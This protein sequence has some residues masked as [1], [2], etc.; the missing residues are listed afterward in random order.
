M[1]L[2]R[3]SSPLWRRL[4]GGLLALALVV[5]GLAGP[6]VASIG[7]PADCPLSGGKLAAAHATHHQSQEPGETAPAATAVA[8]PYALCV[9]LVAAPPL[10]A[11]TKAPHPAPHRAVPGGG[12]LLH[13]RSEPPT[14]R[15]PRPLA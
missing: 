13:G 14:L 3:P 5:G 9:T 2:R 7:T 8:C 6:A 10:A 4:I 12:A 11:E 1:A 15:P